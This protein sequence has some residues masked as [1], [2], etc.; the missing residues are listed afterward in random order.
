MSAFKETQKKIEDAVVSGHQKIEDGVVGGYQKI[1]DGVVGSYR[2]I[3]DKF[4]D[5]FLARE[6]ETTQEAKARIT[7]AGKND[8]EQK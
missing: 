7:G 2:K 8:G 5:T 6:G 1:E 4:I 3:E